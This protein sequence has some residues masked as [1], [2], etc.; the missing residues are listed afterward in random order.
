MWG[1]EQRDQMAQGGLVEAEPALQACRQ[2]SGACLSGPGASWTRMK[3]TNPR[4]CRLTSSHLR[5][6]A[7]CSLCWFGS[8]S[9]RLD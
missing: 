1:N 9:H 2:R 3:R 8:G 5:C 6:R 7:C 4:L